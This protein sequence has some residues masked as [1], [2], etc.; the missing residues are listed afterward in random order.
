MNINQVLDALPERFQ[1]YHLGDVELQSYEIHV[2]DTSAV[3]IQLFG[4][5][6]ALVVV[7]FPKD[8]DVSTY[9]ELGNVLA[10]KIANHMSLQNQIDIVISPPQIL[11]RT[12]IDQL[13]KSESSITKRTYTH[14]YKN[15][16]IPVS[17]WILP[18]PSEGI[19]YA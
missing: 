9:S 3:A 4:D 19:G 5:L 6:R 17:T 12:Q 8:L 18:A 15:T 10:S 7:L 16:V 2:E 14:C 1:F 13:S 11:N